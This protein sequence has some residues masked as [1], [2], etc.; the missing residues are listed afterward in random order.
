MELARWMLRVGI[1]QAYRGI[2]GSQLQDQAPGKCGLGGQ[3]RGV[4]TLRLRL[5]R[6]LPCRD[7]VVA[8]VV[9]CQK[10]GVFGVNKRE[11][12]RRSREPVVGH[13]KERRPPRPMPPQRPRR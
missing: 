2:S 8:G 11:L 6:A 4:A 9:S 13:M 3:P 5:I 10:R 1:R 12:R 7:A